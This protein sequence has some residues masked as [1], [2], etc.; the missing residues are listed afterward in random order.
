MLG[1]TLDAA[2]GQLLENGQVALAAGSASSTTAAATST[3]RSTGRRRSPRSPTTPSWPRGSPRSRPRW[4]TREETIV[5]ELAAVQGEPV[6]LGG[7]YLVDKAKT[8][9]VMRPSA[10]FNNALAGL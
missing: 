6:D 5:G 3:S 4:P 9:A 7:Y 10:T 1:E 2:T 8:D